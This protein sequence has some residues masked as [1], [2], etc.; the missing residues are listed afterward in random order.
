VSFQR[1]DPAVKLS[2]EE[3]LSL[4]RLAETAPLK[5][6]HATRTA[7]L[8]VLW[9]LVTFMAGVIAYSKAADVHGGTWWTEWGALWGWVWAIGLAVLGAVI[10]SLTAARYRLTL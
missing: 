6:R 4:R 1:D 10:A 2:E 9:G 3:L 7:L 5:R 8:L